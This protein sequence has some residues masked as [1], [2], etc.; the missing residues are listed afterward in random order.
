MKRGLGPPFL[1]PAKLS[2]IMLQTYVRLQG[3]YIV[4]IDIY[5]TITNYERN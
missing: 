4:N 2:L 3:N 5:Q 1:F